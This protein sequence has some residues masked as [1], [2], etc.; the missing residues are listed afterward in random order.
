MG[1]VAG[2][3]VSL[4]KLRA[5]LLENGLGAKMNRYLLYRSK[6]FALC[7]APP[8]QFQFDSRYIGQFLIGFTM[9][10]GK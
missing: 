6:K 8:T 10:L 1:S 3:F 9:E 7:W 4:R 5:L 2:E